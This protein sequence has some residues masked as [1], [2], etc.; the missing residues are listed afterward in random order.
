P[1]LAE[2]RLEQLAGTVDAA[3]RQLVVRLGEHR[4]LD[5]RRLGVLALDR[6]GLNDLGGDAR[7][8]V[9]AE[10][11][12]DLGRPVT[13]QLEQHDRRL[14]GAREVVERRQRHLGDVGDA[15]GCGRWAC[16]RALRLDRRARIAHR[17]RHVDALSSASQLWR[18]WATSSGRRSASTLSSSSAARDASVTGLT[19]TAAGI[20]AGSGASLSTGSAAWAGA[21][22]I[23]PM[24]IGVA[25]SRRAR[26]ALR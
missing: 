16:G 20:A 17:H 25:T 23:A 14:L 19:A 11:L 22:R 9:L 13:A 2:R 5:E 7:D 3:G 1:L 12:Q 6:L 24:S 4:E 15:G 10:Q 8:L 21:A 26:R 18:I